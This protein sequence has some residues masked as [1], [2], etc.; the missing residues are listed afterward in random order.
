VQSGDTLASVEIDLAYDGSGNLSTVTRTQDG[1]VAVV[2]T[3][4]YDSGTRKGVGD[5][6][7]GRKSFSVADSTSDPFTV[8]GKSHAL[9]RK[10]QVGCTARPEVGN[11]QQQRLSRERSERG[12]GCNLCQRSFACQQGARLAEHQRRTRHGIQRVHGR[13]GQRAQL[14]NQVVRRWCG[15]LIRPKGVRSY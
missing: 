6:Q 11:V 7:R 9:G 2:G 10:V 15:S 4:G 14:G 12:E 5:A 13:R 3:Y 1:Q 8:L